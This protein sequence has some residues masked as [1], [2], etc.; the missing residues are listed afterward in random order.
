MKSSLLF[1]VLFMGIVSISFTEVFAQ[2]RT[3]AST[4]S[5]KR[6]R[7]TSPKTV[8]QLVAEL[9]DNMVYIEGG[10]FMMG[11]E[12]DGESEVRV[13]ESPAHPVTLSSFYICKYEVTQELW[14][15]IMG[16]NPSHFKG[17]KLPVENINW[18]T[19]LEFIS[20][21]N[22]LTGQEYRLPTEA[23]WEYAARGGSKSQ[24]F[25]YAG[26]NSINEVSWYEDNSGN[27]T[28]NVGTK[29]PNELGLYDMSGN[30]G[31]WCNDWYG[32]DYNAFSKVKSNP[33]GPSWGRIHVYRGG[34]YFVP[35]KHE[36]VTSRHCPE[37]FNSYGIG[38][39]LAK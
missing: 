8:E 13:E 32:K 4:S 22:T 1:K 2:T 3:K 35:S 9:A 25:K 10:T 36:R 16:D 15:A 37:V 20:R 12:Y 27:K 31:E 28:H 21:L 23:E 33:Q 38:F 24:G 19:C 17:A 18:E 14:K 5:I 34:D 30:V 29:K 26:S 11:A 39:R 7:S 6:S